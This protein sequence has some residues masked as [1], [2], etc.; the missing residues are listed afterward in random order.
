LETN[1]EV[2]FSFG[3]DLEPCGVHSHPREDECDQARYPLNSGE[4]LTEINQTF[5]M[6]FNLKKEGIKSTFLENIINYAIVGSN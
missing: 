6:R 2:D 1:V 3:C 4:S 5:K